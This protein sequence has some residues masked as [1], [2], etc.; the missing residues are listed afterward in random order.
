M[1][2]PQMCQSQSHHVTL[3]VTIGRSLRGGRP[4]RDRREAHW[5]HS[6]Y[7]PAAELVGGG[8]DSTGHGK[9]DGPMTG[10]DRGEWS[11]RHK[12]G[13]YTHTQTH[14]P[15]YHL[16]LSLITIVNPLIVIYLIMAIRV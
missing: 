15:S 12:V 5:E 6:R 1:A 11:T 2:P 14:D 7:L 4:E 16:I 13:L 10:P 8:R 9:G 3:G